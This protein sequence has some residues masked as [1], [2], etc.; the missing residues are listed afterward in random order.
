MRAASHSTVGNEAIRRLVADAVRGRLARFLRNLKRAVKRPGDEPIHDLRVSMRRLAAALLTAK[1]LRVGRP[2]DDVLAQLDGLMRPLG[3]VRD[4]QVQMGLLQAVGQRD[5]KTISAYADLIEQR[6]ARFRA[7]SQKAM[8]RLEAARIKRGCKQVKTVLGGKRG[9]EPGELEAAANAGR[10]VLLRCYRAVQAYRRRALTQR[11]LAALHKMR[12]ALKRL[13]YTSEV[14][15]AAV[16][17]MGVGR[18]KLFG[19]YQ[20]YMGDIHDLDVLAQNIQKFYGPTVPPPVRR[21]LDRLARKRGRIF[22]RLRKS[23][24]KMEKDAFWETR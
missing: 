11:D 1:E 9:A 14:L 5:L 19:K 16:P 10:R 3:K 12:L 8:R 4:A 7:K 22:E 23:F 2:A 6:E 18:L 24:G 20:T 21:V 15:Q 13:R 17:G